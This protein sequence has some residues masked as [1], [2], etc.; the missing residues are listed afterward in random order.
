MQV[1]M[2]K[3][4]VYIYCSRTIWKQDRESITH[5]PKHFDIDLQRKKDAHLDF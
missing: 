3:T 4:Y 2:Y 5:L 1:R